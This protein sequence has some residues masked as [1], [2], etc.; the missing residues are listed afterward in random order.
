[1]SVYLFKNGDF[2]I[3]T[4]KPCQESA[5]DSGTIRPA[6]PKMTG[7]DRIRSGSL[8]VKCRENIGETMGKILEDL[9]NI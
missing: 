7:A 3:T 1:M 9:G 6:D 8:T 5:R 4:G 2:P